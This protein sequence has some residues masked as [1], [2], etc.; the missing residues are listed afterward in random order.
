VGDPPSL[1][2][3]VVFIGEVVGDN[4]ASHPIWVTNYM[5]VHAPYGLGLGFFYKERGRRRRPHPNNSRS[6]ILYLHQYSRSNPELNNP[7]RSIR[8]CVRI[9]VDTLV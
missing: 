1:A 3:L 4:L 9:S 5:E 8:S 6:H 2:P 7:I